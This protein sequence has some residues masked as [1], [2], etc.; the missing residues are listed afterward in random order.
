MKRK[1]A[2]EKTIAA[3]LEV[4]GYPSL[5]ALIDGRHAEMH[6]PAILTEEKIQG[7]GGAF[8]HRTR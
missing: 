8:V 5:D 6:D 2:A 4:L 1:I 7:A 3:M